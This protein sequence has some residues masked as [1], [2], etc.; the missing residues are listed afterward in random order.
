MNASAFGQA[1]E[2]ISAGCRKLLFAYYFE[3]K[4]L[5]EAA[6]ATARAYSGV[7][8]TIDRCLKKL[9]QCLA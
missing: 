6:D 3:G 8:K 2:E 1:L 7:W 9:R 5:R 4:S